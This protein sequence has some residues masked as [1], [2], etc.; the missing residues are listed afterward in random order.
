MKNILLLLANGFETYEA[1]VFIDVFGW[2][3]IDGDKNTKLYTCG[4]TREIKSAFNV[5]VKS[6]YLIDDIDH[7]DALAIPGGFEEYNFYKDAYSQESLELIR[8]F[9]CNDKIIASICVAALP[10]GKS[11]VLNGKNATTYK[12]KR[13]IQL[14]EFGAILT[15]QPIVFEDRIITSWNPSTAINVAFK[16]LETL[17]TKENTE[18]VKKLMGF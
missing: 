6:D 2:N 13:Q 18:K 4:L 16:L 14:K 11:G 1:S 17:T 5:I 12:G 7:F 3:L 8:T 9:H 15:D 10:I